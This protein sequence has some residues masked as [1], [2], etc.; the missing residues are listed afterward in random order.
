MNKSP[1]K[2][3][4]CT[5]E[6]QSKRE[7]CCHLPYHNHHAFGNLK[8]MTCIWCD[9]RFGCLD[10]IRL[11]TRSEH[12]FNC[13]DCI[14]EISTFDDFLNHAEKCKYARDNVSFH[15]LK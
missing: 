2:C 15:M 3:F 8:P 14:K 10:K 11:H 5:K 12:G 13:N 9:M 1:F 7:L 6:F 4:S